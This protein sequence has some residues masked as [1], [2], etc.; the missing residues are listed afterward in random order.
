MVKYAYS[1]TIQIKVLTGCTELVLIVMLFIFSRSV[2]KQERGSYIYR[3]VTFSMAKCQI[4]DLCRKSNCEALH[5]DTT[6]NVRYI[7]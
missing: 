1:G 7:D 3:F 6:S 5:P 2:Q 4:L